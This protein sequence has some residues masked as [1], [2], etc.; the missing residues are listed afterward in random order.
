MQQNSHPESYRSFELLGDLYISKK[1][2]LLNKEAARTNYNK[3]LE[4]ALKYFSENSI[5]VNRVKGK[6]NNLEINS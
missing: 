5:N 1:Q 3:S 4:L 6:I 2:P